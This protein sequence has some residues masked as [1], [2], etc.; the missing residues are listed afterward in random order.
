MAYLVRKKVD[1]T[2]TDQWEL[3]E[4]PLVFGRGEQADIRIMDE[5]LSRQHFA[6]APRGAIYVLQ[7]LKSMNGT[8]VNNERVNECELQIN[9]RIRAGQ[10]V[11][12]F[13]RERPKSLATI[14]GEVESDGKGLRTYIGELGQSDGGP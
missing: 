3:L 10:T 13:L 4:K 11:F 14:M 8:W 7:D 5:R 2:V 9:D 1:G 12:V 6:V